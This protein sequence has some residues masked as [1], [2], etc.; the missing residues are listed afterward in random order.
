MKEEVTGGDRPFS[1]TNANPVEHLIV[2]GE[3][4]GHKISFFFTIEKQFFNQILAVD[5]AWTSRNLVDL[6]V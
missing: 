1:A 4:V 6:A 5:S 3:F 2:E